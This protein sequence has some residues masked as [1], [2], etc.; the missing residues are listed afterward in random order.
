MQ[1]ISDMTVRFI[2]NSGPFLKAFLQ[3]YSK[4][5][6]DETVTNTDF[7]YLCD[8]TESSTIRSSA[9]RLLLAALAVFV[10]TGLHAQF[11]LTGNDPARVRWMRTD[12]PSYRIIYPAGLD[13]LARI[14]GTELEAARKPLSW[15]SGYFS[16]QTFRSRLPV[17]LHPYYPFSNASVVWAPKRMDIYT[18]QDPFAPNPTPW[19]RDLAIHEGRHATQMQFC[20]DG[21]FKVFK[22][23]S[24]EALTGVLSGVYP[25]PAFLEGDA[26]VAETALTQAGRGRQASFLEY[27]APAFDSGDWRDYWQWT[28]GSLTRFAPD[29]YRS[30][31]MLV[32]GTRVFFNDPTFTKDY[33][34]TSV[35]KMRFFNLQHTVRQASGMKFKKSFRTIEEGFR[36][37]WQAEALE[38]A[39]FMNSVQLTESPRLHTQYSNLTLGSDGGIYSVKSSLDRPCSLVKIAPDGSEERLSLFSGSTSPLVCSNGKVFWSE[40]RQDTRWTLGGTSDIYFISTT[41]NP[42]RICRL[43]SGKRLFNPAAA[44]DGRLLSACEYPVTGGTRLVTI[45][46]STGEYAGC[47]T[48]PDGIQM[49]ESAWIGDR[50]FVAGLSD[51]GMGIYEIAGRDSLGKAV[52]KIV[53]NPVPVELSHLG[54]WPGTS[55]L[56]FVSDHSGVLEMYRIDVDS[57]EL[58]QVTSTRYGIS[59]P[60]VDPVS[61]D[62]FYTSLASSGKPEEHRQGRMVYRTGFEELP[63]KPAEYSKIHS[64]PVAEK[65]SEQEKSLAGGSWN[66][67]LPAQ[68]TFSEPTEYSKIR[69]P[70]IHS[71]A[72]LYFEYDNIEN[73]SF[74]EITRSAALGAT[75][76]F[77]NHLSTGYGSAGVEFGPDTYNTDRWRGALHLDYTY[78]GLY[79]VFEFELDVNERERMDVKRVYAEKNF[80]KSYF[81]NGTFLNN[82]SYAAGSVKGYIPFNFSSGG[83]ARGFVP[84]VRFSVSNDLYDDTVYLLQYSETEESGEDSGIYK[85]AGQLGT[86]TPS[87]S[88]MNT[89]ALSAR[90]YVM[91]KQGPSQIFPHLGIGAEAGVVSR[92]GHSGNYR[93]TAYTYAYGYLPGLTS[94]QGIK[95]TASFEKAF[96][97]SA[98]SFPI[99]ALSTGPRGFADSNF[100]SVLSRN[101]R[102]RTCLS[103]D[104][105]VPFLSVDWSFLSPLA[106]VRNFV[107]TPFCDVEWDT[108]GTIPDIGMN[109]MGVKGDT[110]MSV[111]ADLEVILGNFIWL[112]YQ[113]R[114][115][116]R[117]AWNTWNNM[118]LLGLANLDRHYIGM[119]FSVDL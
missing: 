24:G 51:N 84:Q 53:A 110:L 15:S 33:F 11:S 93:T 119:T 95:L 18:L 71:W 59:N 79:P 80:V 46:S 4:Y 44:P 34:W 52:L 61:G 1:K 116:I 54:T 108:F 62:L 37:T 38:R 21:K 63:M 50:I 97:G 13:S 118:D 115:G 22:W 28:Y 77:Q 92:P 47:W 56:T 57:K 17:V 60:V 36:D 8:M 96:G 112:P 74:D 72:P 106:Y 99:V 30:G 113:T 89:L 109:P 55:S 76:F 85:V 7:A 67:G 43:T 73:L 35:H 86:G 26:V 66:E 107:L 88:C 27:L 14:Y 48:A 101:F 25:G 102:T 82:S 70:H 29:Y 65:L 105:S 16:G 117:Y 3:K 42:R 75:A 81:A 78:E 87:S 64:S 68:T 91:Q 6:I 19:A 100:R 39:P 49:T 83:V 98:Y 23:L 103:A 40:A 69:L 9:R 31:Y 94:L 111:G 2:G 58:T 5:P 32:A 114:A 90:G 41:E 45:D 20:G 104:W 10:C 12:T